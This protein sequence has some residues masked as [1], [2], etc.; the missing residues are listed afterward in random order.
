MTTPRLQQAALG[1]GRLPNV[2]AR[3]L[4]NIIAECFA[5]RYLAGGGTPA[6]RLKRLVS[7]VTTAEFRQLLLLYTCRANMILADFIRHFYWER[8]AGGYSEISNVDARVF[9]E[10]AIDRGLTSKRWSE[11]TVRRV[12][13]YL[14][15]CCADYGLLEGGNK[16][17]RKILQYRILPN[18]AAYLAYDLHFSGLGDNAVAAHE[19]W[20]LYGLGRDEVLVELKRLS[21][22]GLLIIQAAG[23]VVRIDWK[24]QDMEAVCDV[25]AQD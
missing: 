8:Y 15:G 17:N 1:S 19:D 2:T 21:L 16:S 20:G 12:S 7:R 23:E 13:A 18:V 4:R 14:T 11:T 5:P 22:K 24:Y 6:R 9:V 3:R 10:R 25:I